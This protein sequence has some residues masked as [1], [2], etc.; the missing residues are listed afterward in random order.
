MRREGGGGGG[1]LIDAVVGFEYPKT[2]FLLVS[3]F[4]INDISFS[5]L[6]YR[7]YVTHLNTVPLH[8]AE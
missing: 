1:G 7:I 2:F 5:P 6:N 4:K 3:V 8:M